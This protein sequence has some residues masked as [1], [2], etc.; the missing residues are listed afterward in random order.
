MKRKRKKFSDSMK[1]RSASFARNNI[2]ASN[3][4]QY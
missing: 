3:T 1:I 2:T 4:F